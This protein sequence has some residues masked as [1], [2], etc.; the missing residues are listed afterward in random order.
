MIIARDWSEVEIAVIKVYS[1]S[2]LK[3]YCTCTEFCTGCFGVTTSP[4][5]IFVQILS[6]RL[7]K[8]SRRKVTSKLRE[9]ALPKETSVVFFGDLRG[10][11]S[12]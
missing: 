10:G 5:D 3:L 8:F 4:L 2:V 1:K 11:S 12:G 9:R 6:S 7:A